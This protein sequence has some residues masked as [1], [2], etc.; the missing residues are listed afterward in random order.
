M[1]NACVICR[2]MC[3]RCSILLQDGHFHDTYF[4]IDSSAQLCNSLQEIEVVL[5]EYVAIPREAEY[6]LMKE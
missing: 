1:V 2:F 6:K 5:Q 4:V 3:A